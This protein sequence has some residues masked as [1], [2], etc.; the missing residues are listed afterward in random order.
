MAKREGRTG[1]AETDEILDEME[2]EGIEIPSFEGAGAAAKEEDGKTTDPE[3]EE[4]EEETEEESEDSDEDEDEED[5]EDDD[6]SEE[7]EDAE[8]DADE[9]DEAGDADEDEEGD[10]EDDA[11]ASGKTGKRLTLVQKYR[12]AKKDLREVRTTL[13]TIQN[14]KSQEQL[15]A[16]IKAYAEKTGMKFEVAKGLIELAAKK[17]GLPQDVLDDLKASR[18]ERRDRDYW[19][20]QRSKFRKDFEGNVLPVLENMGLTKDQIQETY[21][22]LDGDQTSEFWA[23]DKKNKEKS[24][25]AL[26]LG[27]YRDREGGKGKSGKNRISSD[28]GGSRRTSADTAKDPSE[29]TGEDIDSMSDEEFDKF[30]D[31]LGK[32]QKSNIHRS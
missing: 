27:M 4:S 9:S 3:L 26:A 29:M 13:E 1:D 23:W 25:V 7:D 31:G 24:L 11:A 19:K 17:A 12:K 20:E 10:D 15:D 14:A 8:E 28:S 16:E 30:S 2:S 32:G 21:D 6:S 22:K 5:S 18:E